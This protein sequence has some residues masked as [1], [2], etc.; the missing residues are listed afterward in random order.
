MG[1]LC[2]LDQRRL[3][4]LA[5]QKRQESIRQSKIADV[6]SGELF[7]H[8]IHID[9]LGLRKVKSS[10]D[11]RVQDDAVEIGVGLGYTS[12]SFLS[13]RIWREPFHPKD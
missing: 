3:L 8:N 6:I 13:K 11:A 5:L 1:G 10:L 2:S 9:G 4:L 7:L 12:V